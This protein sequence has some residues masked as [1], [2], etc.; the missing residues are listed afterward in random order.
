M[1]GGLEGRGPIIAKQSARVREK[2]QLAE[3][4]WRRYERC[5]SRRKLWSQWNFRDFNLWLYYFILSFH[6]YFKYFASETQRCIGLIPTLKVFQSLAKREE[7]Y[8][9]LLHLPFKRDL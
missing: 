2:W 8:L 4:E 3:Q 6:K 1:H 5:L 9:V 7:M